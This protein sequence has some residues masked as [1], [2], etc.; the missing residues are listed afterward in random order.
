MYI[1]DKPLENNIC[2]VRNLFLTNVVGQKEMLW[3]TIWALLVG[4]CQS[5]GQRK[6][7]HSK[8]NNKN[9]F[10]FVLLFWIYSFLLL[11]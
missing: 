6:K 4:L 8:N 9:V 2:S 10:F 11:L 7:H 3:V 1:H 5:I